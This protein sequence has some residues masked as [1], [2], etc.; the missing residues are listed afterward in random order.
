MDALVTVCLS[1]E[2]KE[3]AGELLWHLWGWSRNEESDFIEQAVDQKVPS[4][5]V[6]QGFVVAMRCVECQF[7]LKRPEIWRTFSQPFSLAGQKWRLYQFTDIAGQAL[8]GKSVRDAFRGKSE[9]LTLPLFGPAAQTGICL[10]ADMPG[11]DCE[12]LERQFCARVSPAS[13]ERLFA[14]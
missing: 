12:I 7:T 2:G 8:Q 3:T 13:V 11:I 14:T 1:E 9:E 6:P 4:C 10:I 5:R